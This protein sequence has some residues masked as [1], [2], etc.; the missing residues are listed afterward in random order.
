MLRKLYR[1]LSKKEDRHTKEDIFID[2]DT[3]ELEGQH[4]QITALQLIHIPDPFEEQSQRGQKRSQKKQRKK[5]NQG[6][7]ELNLKEDRQTKFQSKNIL[8]KEEFAHKELL[9]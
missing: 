8:P 1:K 5:L 6:L 2:E 7:E 9:C 3:Q 4:H